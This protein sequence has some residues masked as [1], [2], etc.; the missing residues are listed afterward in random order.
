MKVKVGN[1]VIQRYH[2]ED[3]INI[4]IEDGY[5]VELE[6]NDNDTYFVIINKV[7]EDLE[8]GID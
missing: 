1:L 7:Y 3:F 8:E 4:L 5:S 2:I 6:K